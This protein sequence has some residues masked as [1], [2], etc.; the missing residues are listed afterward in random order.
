MITDCST[1]QGYNSQHHQIQL[2]LRVIATVRTGLQPTS[3]GQEVIPSLAGKVPHNPQVKFA[4]HSARHHEGHKRWATRHHG[5][6]YLMLLRLVSIHRHSHVNVEVKFHLEC[7]LCFPCAQFMLFQMH[8]TNL[9][10]SIEATYWVPWLSFD[11]TA[12]KHTI[13][14]VLGYSLLTKS[15]PNHIFLAEAY[16]ILPS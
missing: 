6:T 13:S 7:K 3:L 2:L 11:R 14:A 9:S 16:M 15:Q 12:E 8:W 10:V 5:N 4:W 1:K